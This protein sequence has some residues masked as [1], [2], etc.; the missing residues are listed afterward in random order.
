MPLV[1]API[2]GKVVVGNCRRLTTMADG[3]NEDAVAL[4]ALFYPVGAR[5]KE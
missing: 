1:R 4:L 2:D 3:S 5:T